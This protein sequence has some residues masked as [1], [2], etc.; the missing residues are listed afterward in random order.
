MNA[1]SEGHA[2]SDEEKAKLE[3]I[4]NIAEDVVKLTKALVDDA[5]AKLDI[6]RRELPPEVEFVGDGLTY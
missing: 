4:L 6:V 1:E 2:V 5:K 3:A